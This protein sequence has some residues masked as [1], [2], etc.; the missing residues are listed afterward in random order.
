[1]SVPSGEFS[2]K[3]KYRSLL[4]FAGMYSFISIVLTRQAARAL[5]VRPGEVRSYKG[6]ATGSLFD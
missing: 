1:M 3:C 6:T 2:F 4:S 5:F